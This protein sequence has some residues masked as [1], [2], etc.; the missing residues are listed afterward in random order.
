MSSRRSRSGGRMMVLR[1]RIAQRSSRKDPV[2]TASCKS[3]VVVTTSREAGPEPGSLDQSSA[4]TDHALKRG[5]AAAKEVEFPKPRRNPSA[6]CVASDEATAVGA[7]LVDA[8]CRQ[9]FTGPRF[10]D[11][12]DRSRRCRGSRDLAVEKSAADLAPK[13][14]PNEGCAAALSALGAWVDGQVSGYPS[15]ALIMGLLRSDAHPRASRREPPARGH[16][17]SRHG[18]SLTLS[19]TC[20]MIRG[21]EMMPSR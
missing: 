7:L 21:P 4:R 8:F 14:T 16:D 12:G 11:N 1:V 15:V 18:R 19:A 20:S 5:C 10:A 2:P 3:P 17:H 13:P 9:P 6:G